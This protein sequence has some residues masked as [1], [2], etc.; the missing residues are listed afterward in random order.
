MKYLWI[1]KSGLMV[2]SIMGLII[3]LFC[4]LTGYWLLASFISLQSSLLG[5]S[6]FAIDRLSQNIDTVVNKG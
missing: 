1:L 2:I 6:L 3:A 5:F 4:S